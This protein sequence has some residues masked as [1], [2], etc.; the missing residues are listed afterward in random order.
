MRCH[1]FSSDSVRSRNDMARSASRGGDES[2]PSKD[3]RGSMTIDRLVRSDYRSNKLSHM[4]SEKDSYKFNPN[5]R[6]CA[7]L[8]FDK[9]R[10]YFGEARG[11][12]EG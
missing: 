12:R 6:I 11:G 7:V 3:S 1:I 2:E 4:L 8:S 9:L 10:I 5:A